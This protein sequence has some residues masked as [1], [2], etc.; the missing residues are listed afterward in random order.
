VDGGVGPL[1]DPD[2]HIGAVEA[3]AVV[4]QEGAPLIVSAGADS[5]ILVRALSD[6]T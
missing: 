4:E 3:L 2:A 5:A 1:H 6:Q